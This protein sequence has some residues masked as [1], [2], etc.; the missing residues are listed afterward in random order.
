MIRMRAAVFALDADGGKAR[1][2]DFEIFTGYA[3]VIDLEIGGHERKRKN[4]QW[5]G[6]AHN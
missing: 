1:H 4:E 3:N 5:K 6:V 2:H